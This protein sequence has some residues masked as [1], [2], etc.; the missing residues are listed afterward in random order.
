MRRLSFQ[1]SKSSGATSG[2][3]LGGS[4]TSASYDGQC[5]GNHEECPYAL[6]STTSNRTFRSSML[7]SAGT[8]YARGRAED[9][10]GYQD[11]THWTPPGALRADTSPTRASTPSSTTPKHR[12]TRPPVGTL[13]DAR[14]KTVMGKALTLSVSADDLAADRSGIASIKVVRDVTASKPA[15][16]AITTTGASASGTYAPSSCTATQCPQQVSGS[17]SAAN[18]TIDLARSEWA[19]G[20]H[21]ISAIITDLAGN[22]TTTQI[23]SITIDKTAPTFPAGVGATADNTTGTDTTTLSWNAAT[24]PP[25]AG[26]APGSGQHHYLIRSRPTGQGAF[27]EPQTVTATSVA[28]AGTHAGDSIDVSIQAADTADNISTADI[29][30]ITVGGA[31]IENWIDPDTSKASDWPNN[32]GLD[33]T[34]WKHVDE[35][36]GGELGSASFSSNEQQPPRAEDLHAAGLLPRGT[37]RVAMDRARRL[38]HLSRRLRTVGAQR[39]WVRRPRPAPKARRHVISNPVQRRARTTDLPRQ[40]TN[41]VRRGPQHQ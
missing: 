38:G 1:L 6:G 20:T 22:Q 23:Q 11:T 36:N 30:T 9:P 28:L 29:S 37:H 14:N 21:T 25:L 5:L 35:D 3:V 18:W 10:L 16:T 39:C 33:F 27:S 40:A 13:W 8:W 15:G 17:P 4:D 2:P 7:P 34:E 24:D 31:V 12:S 41:R 19:E 32:P 26:G